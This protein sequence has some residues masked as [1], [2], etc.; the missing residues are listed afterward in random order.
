MLDQTFPRS[1]ED[2]KTVGIALAEI[3]R[4]M[5]AGDWVLVVSDI[6]GEYLESFDWQKCEEYSL[7]RDI[8]DLLAAWLTRGGK[9]VYFVD[10]DL[11][12]SEYRHPVPIG[13]GESVAVELW[14]EQ[15]G[16]I[17][18]LHS[19]RNSGGNFVGVACERAFAGDTIGAY[20]PDT[21]PES[22]FR[23]VGPS[24]SNQLADAFRWIIDDDLWRRR[25][26]FLDAKKNV[27]L[28][29]GVVEKPSSGGSHYRVTFPNGARPYI[30]DR[31][32]DP[33][34]DDHLKEIV[35]MV[36]LPFEVIKQTLLSGALP[37]REFLLSDVVPAAAIW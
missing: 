34:L 12:D 20:P 1:S 37:E 17:F 2:L 15:V 21:E 14:S 18:V 6:F 23:L 22:T 7:L 4:G 11:C 19:E 10:C 16:K 35:S 26:S 32:H 3:D 9:T 30:L 28:F 31:N 24:T 25:V 33:Q 36:N 27:T 8:F 29:G 13:S 5:T